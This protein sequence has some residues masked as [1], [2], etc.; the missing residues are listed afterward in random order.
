MTLEEFSDLVTEIAVEMRNGFW[1][2]LFK[3]S[4]FIQI[5]IQPCSIID[6]GNNFI[7]G[8]EIVAHYKIT[9]RLYKRGDSGF[10]PSDNL[11]MD[12]GTFSNNLLCKIAPFGNREFGEAILR[13]PYNDN[14]IWTAEI[15]IKN[16][17]QFLV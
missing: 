1:S 7:G 2:H 6:I 16:K 3:D 5:S 12:L 14:G 10:A 17:K 15:G 8:Y 9:L 11:V 13:P 4:H